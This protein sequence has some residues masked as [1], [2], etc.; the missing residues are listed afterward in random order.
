MMAATACACAADFFPLHQGNTWTYRSDRGET[1]VVQVGAPFFVNQQV[2]HSL[3]GYTP[4]RLLVR[5]NEHNDLVRFDEESYRE[6]LV[7]SFGRLDGGWWE[8]PSR[9][10]DQQGST[11]EKRGA[12]DGPAGPFRDV[13]EI[14]F[15]TFNCADA[16]TESEQYAE[17]IGMVRRVNSSIAGPR[18]FDLVH[19]R[20]G[21]LEI[22]TS[23][24]ATF[25]VS[26]RDA[27]PASDRILAVLQLRTTAPDGIRLKFPGGQEFEAVLRDEAGNDIWRWSDGLVFTEGSH[28][29]TIGAGWSVALT[30]PRPAQPGAYELQAWLTTASPSFAAAVPVA[31]HAGG[32][33]N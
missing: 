5:I 14:S 10:C 24:R 7:T 11:L 21:N 22:D 3:R 33:Q 17:N 28:E 15:R 9:G 18:Q 4:Q 13:L 26:V 31:I 20:I 32:E 6:E 25:K 16:G 1:F 29:V 27:G 23:L 19:A 2:Y 30:I 12:H 8:A